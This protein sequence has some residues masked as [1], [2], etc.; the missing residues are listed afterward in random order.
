MF[1]PVQKDSV[2]VQIVNYFLDAI[3]SGELKDSDR[4][5]PERELCERLGVGRSTLREALRI[6]D[7]MSVLEKRI[8]GTYIHIQSENIIKEAVSID[9][10]VGVTNYA[11]LVE[12]RN[13]LEVESIMEAAANRTEE[14]L[15]KL[16]EVRAKM[17]KTLDDVPLYSKN[18]TEFHIAV[19][20]CSHNEILIEIFEAIRILLY[21]Y[22][23]NNMRLTSETKK[24]YSDHVKMIHAIRAQDIKCCEALMREH[25]DYTLDLFDRKHRIDSL[26]EI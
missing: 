2:P 21:D 6:L 1:S 4:L 15:E 22:Q 13:F 12:V 8:D 3:S 20:R 25:L 7:M 14:D 11:E 24:S 9:F 19:A 17:E 26:D 16:E 5:P 23:R 18:S 10:A